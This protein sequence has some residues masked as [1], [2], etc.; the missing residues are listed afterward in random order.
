MICEDVKCINSI[1]DLNIVVLDGV[2]KANMEKIFLALFTV[3]C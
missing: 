3:G 1:K 2:T